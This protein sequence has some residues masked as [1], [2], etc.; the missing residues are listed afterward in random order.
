[1]LPRY[2]VQLPAEVEEEH[3]CA[4]FLVTLCRMAEPGRADMLPPFHRK[5]ADGISKVADDTARQS[6]LA[7]VEFG[8]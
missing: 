6:P 3:S 7:N 8:I 1:M 2:N 4:S 5:L